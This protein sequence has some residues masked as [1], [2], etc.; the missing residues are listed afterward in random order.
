MS[1]FCV[2]D[3]E[4]NESV[5]RSRTVVEEVDGR[6]HD[7]YQNKLCEALKKMREEMDEQLRQNNE[8][9]E[10]FYERKVPYVLC[11]VLFLILF[12]R[13]YSLSARLCLCLSFR[14]VSMYKVFTL[15]GDF[16]FPLKLQS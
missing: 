13:F 10:A 14:W 8:E 12:F 9:T 4:L 1:I 7:D 3:Q 16:T 15:G 5:S 6:I 2:V 11:F